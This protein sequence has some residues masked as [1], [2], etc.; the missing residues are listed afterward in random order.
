MPGWFSHYSTLYGRACLLCNGFPRRIA[1]R[2][3]STQFSLRN[4]ISAFDDEALLGPTDAVPGFS[5]LSAIYLRVSP[6]QKLLGLAG[7]L[8][9]RP[10]RPR[11][12]RRTTLA[13]GIPREE[14]KK[15]RGGCLLRMIAG[16]LGLREGGPAEPPGARLFP[17]LSW[18]Q[19]AGGAQREENFRS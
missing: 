11:R 1:I 17:R 14:G 4:R 9:V 3:H 18:V 15:G 6:S 13:A 12:Q 7:E 5:F 10:K 2:S 16:L 19:V 8:S